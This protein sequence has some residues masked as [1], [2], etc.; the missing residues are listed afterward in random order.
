MRYDVAWYARRDIQFYVN[1]FSDRHACAGKQG[2]YCQFEH[3][4]W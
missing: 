3:N 2:S 1:F 4:K